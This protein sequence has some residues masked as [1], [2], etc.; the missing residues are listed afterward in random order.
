MKD[1]FGNPLEI[2]DEIIY[3]GVMAHIPNFREG[4]I[5]ILDEKHD[6]GWKEQPM[7][8]VLGNNNSRAGWTYPKRT[9]NKKYV[10]LV[11]DNNTDSIKSSIKPKS[12]E[13]LSEWYPGWDENKLR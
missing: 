10:L 11:N 4:K 5:L 12:R 13:S 8:K 6:D 7:I 9:I 3:M 1:Y 2:G